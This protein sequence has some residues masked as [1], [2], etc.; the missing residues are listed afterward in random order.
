MSKEDRP[1][2]WCHK[3]GHIAR[4]CPEKKKAERPGLRTVEDSGAANHRATFA[5][6]YEGYKTAQRGR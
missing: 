6:D 4:D 5:V 2:F 1:C 3:P